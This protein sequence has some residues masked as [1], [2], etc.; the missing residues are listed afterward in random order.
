M[1]SQTV[2]VFCL[3][4]DLLKALYHKEDRQCWLSDAEVMTISLVAALHFGGNLAKANRFLYEHRYLSYRNYS[5]GMRK[6]GTYG[7]IQS[8]SQFC[9]I[10]G[11]RPS[12]SFWSFCVIFAIYWGSSATP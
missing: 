11:C 5:Q 12:G 2:A 9:T 3:L 6:I 4:D 8:I 1:D 7:T 10:Y